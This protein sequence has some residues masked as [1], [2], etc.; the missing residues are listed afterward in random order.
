MFS[1][2]WCN[3]TLSI[4][5]AKVFRVKEKVSKNILKVCKDVIDVSKQIQIQTITNMSLVLLIFL[6]KGRRKLYYKL[7]LE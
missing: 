7:Y 3:L 5:N 2:I 1:F 6:L 4:V